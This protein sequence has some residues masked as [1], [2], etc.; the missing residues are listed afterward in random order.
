MGVRR[1]QGRQNGKEA[2]MGQPCKYNKKK[3]P[4]SFK[5]SIAVCVRKEVRSTHL[6]KKQEEISNIIKRA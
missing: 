4:N 1:R 3:L 2:V 6:G 5:N